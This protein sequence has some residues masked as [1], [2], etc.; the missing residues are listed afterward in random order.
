VGQS[1]TAGQSET[2][3][4]LAYLIEFGAGSSWKTCQIGESTCV[5]IL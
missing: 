2:F 4:Y 3:S 1:G 5:I